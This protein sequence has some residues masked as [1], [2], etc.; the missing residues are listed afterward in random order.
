MQQVVKGVDIV[1]FGENAGSLRPDSFQ[2]YDF[3]FDDSAGFIVF[4]VPIARV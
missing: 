3:G 1:L 2:V 4:G